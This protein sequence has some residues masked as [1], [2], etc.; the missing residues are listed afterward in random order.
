[1]NGDTQMTALAP[2]L[3]LVEDY[4]DLAE[5]T[6]EFLRQEGFEVQVVLTGREAIQAASTFLPEIV[7]CDI[8]LPDM[9]GFD[10]VKELRAHPQTEH[11]LLAIHSGITESDIGLSERELR[12]MHVD[13]FLTKPLTVEKVETLRSRS[14]KRRRTR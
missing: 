10:V 14:K 11:A 9:S 13:L 7:L 2:K 5:T 8:S 1:M 6:A 3:L 4:P 12:T